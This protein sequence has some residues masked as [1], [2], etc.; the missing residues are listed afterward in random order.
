MVFDSSLQCQIMKFS[1]LDKRR[2]TMDKS[3]SDNI[4]EVIR[5]F[6]IKNKWQYVFD[7]ATGIYGFDVFL[8][9]ADKTIR[10]MV[11]VRRNTYTVIVNFSF[12]D[13]ENYCSDNRLS[14]FTNFVNEDLSTGNFYINHKNKEICY[15]LTHDLRKVSLE[16]DDVE[17][18]IYYAAA[19]LQHYSTGYEAVLNGAEPTDSLAEC[20]QKLVNRVFNNIIRKKE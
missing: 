12:K 3:Y 11:D 5:N 2:D 4:S 13:N 7:Q 17:Q 9:D 10:Y 20:R 18:K 6:L 19:K 8:A 16:V 15:K 1:L 14:E